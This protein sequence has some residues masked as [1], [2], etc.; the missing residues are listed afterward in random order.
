M[1]RALTSCRITP[2]SICQLRNYPGC[3][4]IGT[5]PLTTLARWH[6]KLN[7]RVEH[8]GKDGGPIE[9]K[10]VS[11]LDLCRQWLVLLR[12]AEIEAEALAANPSKNS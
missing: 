7:D 4:S 5:V 10:D 2:R 9:T 12:K 6:G 1:L 11:N 8:T 3:T